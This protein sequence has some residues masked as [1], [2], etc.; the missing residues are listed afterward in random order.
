MGSLLY[1]VVSLNGLPSLPATYSPSPA[2]L[3]VRNPDIGAL[4]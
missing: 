4:T 2:P 3:V 1:M